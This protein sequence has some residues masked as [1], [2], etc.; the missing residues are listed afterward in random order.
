M[1]HSTVRSGFVDVLS[2]FKG[3]FQTSLSGAKTRILPGLL[4]LIPQLCF[5]SIHGA[6]L[7]FVFRKIDGIIVPNPILLNF[8]L[9]MCCVDALGDALFF[10][11]LWEYCSSLRRGYPLY[12][13][14]APGPFLPKVL[15]LR[16][17]LP[18]ALLGLVFGA[19]AILQGTW[20]FSANPI[21]CFV[22]IA[23]GVV[24]HIT[25][26]SAFH[27][28]QAYF[29]PTLP[30]AL[31]SPASRLYTKPLHLT[32]K[33]G[34]FATVLL[35]LYPAYFITAFPSGFATSHF[36]HPLVQAWGSAVLGIG[37]VVLIPWWLGLDKVVR[38]SCRK[39]FS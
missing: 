16:F 8:F 18:M 22:A 3:Y 30:I 9:V 25:L 11:G 23:F 6:I 37:F 32:L 21:V 14:M 2:I 24:T 36:L 28:V 27:I 12:Y 34:A 17:D 5:Y 13:L 39:W 38:I 4:E 19:L 31:G 15:F 20:A 10:K 1:L 29:D 33:S 35:F 26:T 7:Y